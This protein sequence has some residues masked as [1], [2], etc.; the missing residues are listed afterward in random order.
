MRKL[1][2]AVVVVAVLGSVGLLG[3]ST[4]Y[5]GSGTGSGYNHP[6]PSHKNTHRQQSRGRH[7]HGHS[8]ERKV[9]IRQSTSCR[10]YEDNVDVLG[11]FRVADGWG[12]G[13][14]GD[15]RRDWR[16]IRIGSSEGCNNIIRL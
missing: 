16:P 5:A 8:H 1:H 13:H 14:R 7:V 4:A 11:R 6:Q 15:E 2:H 10:T 3:T 9:I 12:H